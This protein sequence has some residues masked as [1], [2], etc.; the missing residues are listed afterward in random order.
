LSSRPPTPPCVPFGTR[1]FLQFTHCLVGVCVGDFVFSYLRRTVRFRI[2]FVFRTVFLREAPVCVPLRDLPGLAVLLSCLS[3]IHCLSPPEVPPSPTTS[4]LPGTMVL[5]TS[6]DKSCFNR[7]SYALF[8]HVRET[9]PGKSVIFPSTYLPH[10]H[11]LFRIAIGLRL[12]L[13]PYPQKY[14]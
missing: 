5:L 6:H 10:L 3:N 9:S 11:L 4:T 13:Q 2:S 1:R 7:A 8:P 12:V 14:A